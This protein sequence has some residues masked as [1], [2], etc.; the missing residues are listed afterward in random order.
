MKGRFLLV[1][2]GLMLAAFTAAL[3]YFQFYAFYD[4]LEEQPLDVMGTVYPVSAW[5]GIDAF[6]SPLKK[7]V[8]LSVSAETVARIA[9]EQSVAEDAEPLVAPDWFECFDARQISRDIDA[10]RA[11]TYLMGGSDFDGVDE[12]LALYPDGRGY[13]WRQLKPEFRK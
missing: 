7:R 1:P 8:C 13:V 4:E 9:A 10:G 5:N 12:Y 2:A 3:V 11:K 6:S